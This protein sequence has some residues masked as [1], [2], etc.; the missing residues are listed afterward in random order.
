VSQRA[1]DRREAGIHRSIRRL[2][3]SIVVLL[4]LAAV[5]PAAAQAPPP[6]LGTWAGVYRDGNVRVN[7]RVVLRRLQIGQRAGTTRYRFRG[8]TC[9]G[10]LTLR[11][12]TP[13]G[14]VLRDRLRSG[15]RRLCTNG[16]TMIVKV[17]TNNRLRTRVR[18]GRAVLRI[19]LRRR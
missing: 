2:A 9:R 3:F 8:G 19:T 4:V 16:D 1:H 10:R 17:V 14:Y 7:M 12:R 18:N 13:Q 5:V 15:P 6:E 11:A